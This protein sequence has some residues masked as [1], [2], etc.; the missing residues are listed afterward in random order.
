MML[1]LV[2]DDEPDPLWVTGPL[3]ADL[4]SEMARHPGR[5]RAPRIVR[6]DARPE[7][8]AASRAAAEHV[9]QLGARR[10]AVR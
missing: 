5:A 3:V 9:R 1:L 2:I 7:L 8:V 6:T 10:G 4:A